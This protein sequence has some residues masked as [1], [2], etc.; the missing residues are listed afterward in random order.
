M[1]VNLVKPSVVADH[2]TVESTDSAGVFS[3]FLQ[4]YN[5][6]AVD[7]GGQACAR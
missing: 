3:G 2:Q 6:C 4:H 7:V 5:R 1:D